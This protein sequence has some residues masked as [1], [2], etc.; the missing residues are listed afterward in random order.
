MSKVS[1]EN[2]KKL[3]KNL[4]DEIAQIENH[5]Q[6]A[7]LEKRLEELWAAVGQEDLE[8][9]LWQVNATTFLV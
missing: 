6:K 8:R 5:E 4:S 9:D 2:L 3:L 7:A 1:E